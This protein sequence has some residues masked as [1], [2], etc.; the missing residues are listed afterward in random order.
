[1]EKIVFNPKAAKRML[2]RAFLRVYEKYEEIN[3]ANEFPVPDKDTGSNMAVTLGGV[4]AQVHVKDYGGD[5]KKFFADIE[6][7]LLESMSG[8]AGIISAQFLSSFFYALHP[9]DSEK[10]DVRDLQTAFCQARER[11]FASVH[12]PKEGTMLDVI[13][14]AEAG[15][16]NV[17]SIDI[18]E[19]FAAA[20]EGAK[21]DLP[22]TNKRLAKVIAQE[23]EREADSE[24]KRELADMR[25]RLEKKAAEGIG[26]AG[27]VGFVFMLEGL[28]EGMFSDKE[29]VIPADLFAETLLPEVS[30]IKEGVNL[31]NPYEAQ[32]VLEIEDR[33]KEEEFERDMG[34]LGDSLDIFATAE[35][36]YLRVHIHT[37]NVI[38][39]QRTAEKYGYAFNIR[40]IDMREE[41]KAQRGE[42]RRLMIVTDGGADL[43]WSVLAQGV[44]V[45]PFKLNFPEQRNLT[46][47]FYERVLKAKHW[48]TTSQP[49]LGVFA[50]R[51]KD[52][53]RLADEVLV[54]TISSK[55]S[56]SYDNVKQVATGLDDETQRRARIAVFD[57][58]QAAC[59]QALMVHKAIEMAQAGKEMFEIIG[60][61]SELKHTIKLY[62]FPRDVKYLIRSGRLKQGSFKA[63]IAALLQKLGFHL[64]LNLENG[65]IKKAGFAWTSLFASELI[66]T[67]VN[68][69]RR[70]EKPLG[71]VRFAIS[72]AQDEEEARKLYLMLHGFEVFHALNGQQ[73]ILFRERLN[74]VVGVRSGPALMLAWY[75]EDKE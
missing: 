34:A 64:K 30:D 32:F 37:S 12:N 73:E 35:R 54:I 3:A 43:P 9:A 61:L 62:G 14:A 8:N 60:A 19:V 18:R 57:S 69:Y 13:K 2:G 39:V 15:A 17:R 25:A 1:M 5:F 63:C 44:L 38:G 58:G 24:R 11:A 68:S 71:K 40:V 50:K 42:K 70:T 74:R 31:E 36:D 59:G 66:S 29:V 47:P 72:Y 67:V 22:K 45:A 55:L 33:T 46:G 20:V 65:E 26:D 10:L 56:G 48:P 75:E 6:E 4:V 28:Y 53:L 16:Q 51:I 27:A 21:K 41:I 23:L 52:A 7:A 49:S